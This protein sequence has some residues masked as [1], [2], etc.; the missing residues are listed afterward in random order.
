MDDDQESLD[1]QHGS[2]RAAYEALAPFYDQFTAHYDY[3]VWLENLIPALERQGLAKIGCLLD[4]GC[5]SGKSFLPMVDRGWS[6]TACDISPAMVAL[7]Q[8]KAEDKRVEVSV[9]DA[10]YL[11]D[12]GAF[13]LVWCLDDVLNYLPSLPDL[14]T[15]LGRMAKNLGPKGLLAFDLNTLLSF[16]TFWAQ[17]TVIERAGRRMTWKG[18]ADANGPPGM[19]AE[20]N[21]LVEPLSVDDPG[22]PVTSLHRQRHHPEAGVLQAIDSAGLSCIGVYGIHH[23]AVM[24]QPLDEGDHTKA[25]Y[26]ARQG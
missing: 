3:E 10:R 16:R 2:A 1:K 11:P 23:D 20:A 26:L 13:D 5:G 25:I 14:R 24:Q 9:A 17:E 21:I 19:I 6:V 12:F 18:R 4:V 15:A 7:A 22:V 8:S